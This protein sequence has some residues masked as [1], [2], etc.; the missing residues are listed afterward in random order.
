MLTFCYVFFISALSFSAIAVPPPLQ[1]VPPP[2]R[3]NLVPVPPPLQ[4]NLVPVPPP[5]QPN[6]VPVPPPLQPNL[7]PVQPLLQANLVLVPV[8]H[9]ELL[10]LAD[11]V[12]GRLGILPRGVKPSWS[13]CQFLDDFIGFEFGDGVQKLNTFRLERKL[14]AIGKGAWQRSNKYGVIRDKSGR[15]AKMVS[16]RKNVPANEWRGYLHNTVWGRLPGIVGPVSDSAI[17]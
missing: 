13:H 11:G 9:N 16:Y 14:K 5:L 17:I 1:P 6:L 3:P 12:W 4:P 2:L 10:R 8:P 7:V 15:P